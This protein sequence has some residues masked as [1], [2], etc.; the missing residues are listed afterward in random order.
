MSARAHLRFDIE[1]DE[2]APR[3]GGGLPRNAI[4]LLVGELGAGKSLLCQ[5]LAYGLLAH[6]ARVAYASTE[7]RLPN[8][9]AQM[10]SVGYGVEDPLL[11]RSL[12]F[13]AT[14]PG[15]GRV[16][17]KAFQLLRLLA[18]PL[19]SS[20]DVILVDR[21]STFL[22]HARELGPGRHGIV[23]VALEHVSKWASDGRTVVLAVDPDDLGPEEMGALEA[24]ADA[25][26]ELRTEM[27]GSRAIHLLRVRRFARPQ[28]RVHDIIAFRV[29]P[30]IG[31]AIEIKEVYG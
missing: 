10:R 29:E 24:A 7:L 17:P 25:Y 2:L 11:D 13:Y 5:R 20:H 8:F 30:G 19:V 22:R 26:L 12:G 6:G 31:L 27:V 23:D 15:R 9:L 14:R 28:H 21:F 18:S 3:L 1:R 4:V 16:V